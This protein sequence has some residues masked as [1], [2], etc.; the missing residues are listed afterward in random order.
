MEIKP[1][2]NAYFDNCSVNTVV[3]KNTIPSQGSIV[4]D[5]LTF[6]LAIIT[7]MDTNDIRMVGCMRG[8]VRSLLRSMGQ[9]CVSLTVLWSNSVLAGKDNY[10]IRKLPDI[11]RG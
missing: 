6:K 2:L 7:S 1:I 11:L 10:A 8:V 9:L 3:G 4:S 5:H